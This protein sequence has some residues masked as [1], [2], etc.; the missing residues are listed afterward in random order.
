MNFL[1]FASTFESVKTNDKVRLRGDPRKYAVQIWEKYSANP[2][3]NQFDLHY[4]YQLLRYKP[5]F[6]RQTDALGTFDDT[7]EG[8][9][10]AWRSFLLT[11]EG[12]AKVP[13]WQKIISD[14]QIFIDTCDE[15]VSD[16]G[17]ENDNAEDEDRQEQ[18][19]WMRI[20]QNIA[21]GVD[22]EADVS[23]DSMNYWAG[24]RAQL[25]AEILATLDNWIAK[26]KK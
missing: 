21:G 25:S 1:E 8:W 23:E 2:N 15:E 16:L 17:V 14:A 12:K 18:E 20:Q 13:A 9:V 26:P 4:K 22:V 11:D 6:D 24:L 7:A 5:W 3:G 19:E 10:E